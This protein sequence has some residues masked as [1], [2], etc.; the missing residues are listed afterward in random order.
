MRGVQTSFRAG[1][2]NICIVF[3]PSMFPQIPSVGPRGVFYYYYYYSL[4]LFPQD[5]PIELKNDKNETKQ[6][7][8]I[9]YKRRH[10]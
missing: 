7:L 5:G 9:E 10:I 8:L 4:L 3:V 2:S 1:N 6:K